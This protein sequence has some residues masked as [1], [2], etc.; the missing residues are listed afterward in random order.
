MSSTKT[1]TCGPN[2]IRRYTR[3]STASAGSTGCH[4]WNARNPRA[5]STSTRFSVYFSPTS[6]VS[7]SPGYQLLVTSWSSHWTIWPTDAANRRRL[8]SRRL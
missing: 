4:S 3:P 1:S 8:S 2:G 6:P 7:T 5:A